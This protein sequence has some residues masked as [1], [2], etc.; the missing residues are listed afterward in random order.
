VRSCRANG[1]VQLVEV[2]RHQASQ[3][4]KDV[5]EQLNERVA[6]RAHPGTFTMGSPVRLRKSFPRKASRPMAP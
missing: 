6:V 4:Q 2:E 3:M 1:A 5:R